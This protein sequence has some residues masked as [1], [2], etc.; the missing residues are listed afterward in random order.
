MTSSTF[1]DTYEYLKEQDTSAQYYSTGSNVKTKLTLSE[2]EL[3]ALIHYMDVVF[4][5]KGVDEFVKDFN[6]EEDLWWDI[7]STK[8]VYNKLINAQTNNYSN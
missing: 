3:N 4:E 8:S 2:R 6:E 7:K 1:A 5:D